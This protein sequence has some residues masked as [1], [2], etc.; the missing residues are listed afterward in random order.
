VPSHGV[1]I[2]LLMCP[3]LALGCTSLP[4]VVPGG[5]PRPHVPVP[6]D[7]A[8]QLTPAADPNPDSFFPKPHR[9]FAAHFTDPL[10]YDEGNEFSPFGSDEGWDTL[11]LWVERRNEVG[12]CTTAR[13]LVE[14][15]DVAGALEDPDRNGPDIDGFV[16]GAGFA[17]LYLTGHIDSEGKQLT[18]AALHRTYSY[19]AEGNPREQ[20]VMIRDLNRF[21]ASDCPR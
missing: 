19:Y 5:G 3:V 9:R 20:P 7:A 4:V 6:T 14:S 10:Y 8:D 2:S 18:L 11:A 13:W 15:E 16:I 12:S 21:P 1:V 17:L